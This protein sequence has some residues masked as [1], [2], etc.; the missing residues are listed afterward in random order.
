MIRPMKTPQTGFTMVELMVTLT[1]IGILAAVAGPSFVSTINTSRLASQS[2]ELLALIQFARSEAIRSNS[3][4]TFCGTA[5]ENASTEDDCDAGNQPHWVV[6]GPDGQ[7]RRFS[8][9]SPVEVS[10]EL[11][12]VTFAADGLAREGGVLVAGDITVC[13]E[14]KRP[15]QNRRV[16]EISSGSRVAITPAGDGEGT[17][18]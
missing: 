18:P 10:T 15:A 3:R 1:I 7:L 6:I 12:Q 14:T 8:V 9:R 16:V 2:N 4:V 17:C 5:K 11:E 13:M